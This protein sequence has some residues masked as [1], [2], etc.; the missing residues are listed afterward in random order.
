MLR[1]ALWLICAMKVISAP[2]AKPHRQQKH[3]RAQQTAVGCPLL[4]LGNPL[5]PPSQDERRH[6]RRGRQQ[7]D[8]KDQLEAQLIDDPGPRGDEEHLRPSDGQ[9][10][11]ADGPAAVGGVDQLSDQCAAG[12]G[13]HPE[14][15]AAQRGDG[16]HRPQLIAEDEGG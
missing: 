2:P 3:H 8:G 1:T 10:V 16:E 13:Q 15:K 12:D 14:A 4:G 11:D 5:D 9:P 6:H 7:A